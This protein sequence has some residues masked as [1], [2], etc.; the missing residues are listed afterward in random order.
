M[1]DLLSGRL[2]LLLPGLAALG[3]LGCCGQHKLNTRA[4]NRKVLPKR[5]RLICFLVAAA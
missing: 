5:H 3:Y 2:W 4:L 1:L